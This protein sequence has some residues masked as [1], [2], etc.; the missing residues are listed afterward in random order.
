MG[1]LYKFNLLQTI[2]DK[3]ELFWPLLFPL[4]MG[5]LFYLSFGNSTEEQMDAIPVA[6][7]KEG[8]QYFETFLEELDGD[9]LV[10]SE[11]EEDEAKEAL[12]EGKIEGIFYSRKIPSL[13]VAGMQINESIL[14]S[15]L[16]TYVQNQQMMEEI[17]KNN[18]LKIIS[19]VD[20]VSDYKDF[21]Q[22]T[23]VSGK[24]LEG[25]MDFFFALIG[26]AC[27]FGCFMGMKMAMELRADQSALAARRTIVP[28][29]RLS[30]VVS[31]MLSVFTVQFANI[32]ILLLYLHFALG[33]SFGT[34]WPLLI[35]VCV[36]GSTAGVAY[37]IFIGCLRF[38]EGIKTALL[39][40]G[41][42]L[43]SFLSGLMLGGMRY[44]VERYCPIVN[45]INPVALISDA[46][47]SVSIYNN[48]SR[49]RMNLLILAA[50]TVALVL[51]SFLKL[52]RERYDS[53]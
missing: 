19:A 44:I 3:G 34:Q 23:D 36:L 31:G 41:S 9:T 51:V 46:F 14:E 28:A 15:L 38:S 5:T 17:G 11:M 47:Y 37:G 35:P 29:S 39:V 45:R 4:I 22:R 27:M 6:V 8:N 32:C 25:N 48:P 26:M 12:K 33:I 20:A 13:R 52:R 43:M 2:R 49:Y 10:L 16:G 53:L 40:V 30:M 18:P 42:L 24:S 1:R 50:I 7:V 21:V